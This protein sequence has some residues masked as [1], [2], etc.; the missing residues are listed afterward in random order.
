MELSST[1][2]AVQVRQPGQARPRSRHFIKFRDCVQVQT[3]MS[4]R[5]GLSLPKLNTFNA[6]F[7]VKYRKILECLHKEMLNPQIS[8]LGR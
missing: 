6:D 2:L 4:S 7:P 5:P 8:I 3:T 1:L